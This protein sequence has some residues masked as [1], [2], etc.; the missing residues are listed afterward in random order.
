MEGCEDISSLSI[1]Y[2]VT[3]VILLTASTGL[4]PGAKGDISLKMMGI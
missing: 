4:Y 2:Y 3:L 1:T